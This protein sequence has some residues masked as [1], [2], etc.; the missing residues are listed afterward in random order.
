MKITKEEIKKIINDAVANSSLNNFKSIDLPDEPMWNDPIIGFAAGN[1]E[2]FQF[3]KKDIGDFYWTPSEAFHLKYKDSKIKDQD[4]TVISFGFAQT[5]ETKKVQTRAEG[6][7]S[8]KWIVTRGEWESFVYDLYDKILKEIDKAGIRAVAIDLIPEWSRMSSEKYGIASKWSHRHTAY[9][10]GLGTFGLSDGLITRQGKAMRFC[11]LIIEDKLP[12]DR[13][14]YE[15]YHEWCK[16]YADGTCGACIYRCP[17][18][19]ITKKGHDK[20][21][22]STYLQLIKNKTGPDILRNSNYIS[23]CGLCQSRVPCQD[24]VPVK[25]NDD[26]S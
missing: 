19:A 12:A 23:G 2:L 26:H 20:D 22:C 3:Y 14:P 10:A 4:L 1:D 15:K 18:N 24:K 8:L 16:F 25:I 6:M 13:R 9:A 5:S 17:V 7:P 11:S 21:V